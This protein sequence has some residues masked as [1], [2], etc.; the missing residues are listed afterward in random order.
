MYTDSSASLTYLARGRPGMDDD[1]LIPSS[2]QAR[3]TCGGRFRPA[4]G[5]VNMG[6]LPGE[7]QVCRRNLVPGAAGWRLVARGMRISSNMAISR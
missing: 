3:W 4:G 2:R 5:S 1:G 6:G 7:M